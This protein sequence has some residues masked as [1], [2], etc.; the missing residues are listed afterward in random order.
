MKFLK[1]GIL[2]LGFSIAAQASASE[3]QMIKKVHGKRAHF[4]ENYD[5]KI[6]SLEDYSV[7]FVSAKNR[8]ATIRKAASNSDVNVKLIRKTPGKS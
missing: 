1:V 8:S 3:V 5:A 6:A 2:V 4:L 7:T